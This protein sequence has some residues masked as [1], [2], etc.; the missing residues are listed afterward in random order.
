MRLCK[1]CLIQKDNS[2]FDKYTRIKDGLSHKCKDC[3]KVWRRSYRALNRGKI[4]N[5]KR[6]FY[7]ENKEKICAATTIYYNDNKKKLYEKAKE[8]A[9]K[10]RDEENIFYY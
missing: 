10:N 6:E 4:N 5:Y 1:T 8:W 2:C 9:E 7:K 3:M